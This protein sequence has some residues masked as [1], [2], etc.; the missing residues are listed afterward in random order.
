MDVLLLPF[1]SDR[2]ETAVVNKRLAC[3]PSSWIND[4]FMVSVNVR[5]IASKIADDSS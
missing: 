3:S 4:K 1:V 2:R 5:F